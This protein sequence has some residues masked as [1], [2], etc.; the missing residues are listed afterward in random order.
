M[1]RRLN[2]TLDPETVSLL[3]RLSERYYHGNKSRTVQ[4]ALES[5]ASHTG[6]DGWVI[7]GYTPLRV[8]Q[9]IECHTCG[10]EHGKG[11]LLYRPV[12]ERG[13]SPRALEAIPKEDWLECSSCVESES[14]R[15][16]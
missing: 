4:A 16:A 8:E 13:K 12:F 1:K 10:K 11:D 5:L 15:T 2:F 9:A 6:H 3:D 7:S 14:P